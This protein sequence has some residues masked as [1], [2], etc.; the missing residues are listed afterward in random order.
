MA[1]RPGLTDT[2]YERAAELLSMD[3][4]EVVKNL[5]P[6]EIERYE[7]CIR[8]VVEARR[9]AWANEGQIFIA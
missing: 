4:D 9:S 8:S 6:E 7:A 2:E 5:P 1:E 3:L